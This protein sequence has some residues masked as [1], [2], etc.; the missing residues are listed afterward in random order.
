MRIFLGLLFIILS[1]AIP[2]QAETQDFSAWLKELRQ[3]AI[4]FGISPKLVDEALPDT[5]V[6]NAKV[7]KLD[8][9]QPETKI[10]F[11]KYKKNVVTAKRQ[12]D[13]RAYLEAHKDLLQK[14]SDAYGVEPQY[15]VALWGIETGFGKNTGGFEVIPALVTLAYEGRRGDFFRKELLKALRIVDQGNIPLHEMKGSWAG[16]MGQCQFM[17][18]SFEAFAQDFDKD[19]KKDIWK[20]EADVFASTANYLAA[21]GWKKGQPWG[22]QV[23]LPKNFDNKMVDSKVKKSLQFWNDAGVR[24]A[25]GQTLSGDANEE[26]SIVQPGG[27][28]YKIYAVYS[29]YRIL[30]KWNASLYFATSVAQLA[31]HLKG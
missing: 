14:V 16:A 1:S 5:L 4:Q 9:K 25:E 6:P 18:S 17:P 13:G 31:G 8:R 19:G 27:E 28:G 3:E 24:T 12:Q 10:T 2:A 26:V 7:V 23:K 22:T 30:L 29:N 15:I 20:S 21:S 11:E